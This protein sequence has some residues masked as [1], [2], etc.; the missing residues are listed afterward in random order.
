MECP[1]LPTVI[2]TLAGCCQPNGSCGVL[3]DIVGFGCAEFLP[4]V[5]QGNKDCT[6]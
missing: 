6:Y 2:G 1:D 5:L 4:F 3:D